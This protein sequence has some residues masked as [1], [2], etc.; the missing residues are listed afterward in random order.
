MTSY[1]CHNSLM[2]IIDKRPNCYQKAAFYAITLC[3]YNWGALVDLVLALYFSGEALDYFG[4]GF[5][6]FGVIFRLFWGYD[7]GV[8]LHY[9]GKMYF[10]WGE[11]YFQPFFVQ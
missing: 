2:V 3:I 11:K 4:D 6:F 9:L 5:H 1:K 10:F 7:F 8:Y